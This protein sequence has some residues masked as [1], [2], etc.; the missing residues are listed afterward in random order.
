[1]IISITLSV[2]RLAFAISTTYPH[3]ETTVSGNWLL[4]FSSRLTIPS[5]EGFLKHRSAPRVQSFPR[6]KLQKQRPTTV[7]GDPSLHNAPMNPH[8]TFPARP[9]RRTLIGLSRH[10]HAA[11]NHARRR[12][13]CTKLL[14]K[15]KLPFWRGG[16]IIRD[17]LQYRAFE[18]QRMPSFSPSLG[19]GATV[20]MSQVVRASR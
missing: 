3:P 2:R 15:W 13:A 4:L 14:Q 17:P 10:H 12:R 11:W 18:I 16:L 1:L 20:T 5:S 6:W 8:D 7:K 9:H 19:V